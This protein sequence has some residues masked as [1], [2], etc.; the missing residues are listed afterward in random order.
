MSTRRF[1]IELGG[2]PTAGRR[3]LEALDLA[4]G[5][6]AYEHRVTLVLHPAALARLAT[7]RG[8][9]ELA[10]RL[11]RVAAT[12]LEALTGAT[13]APDHVGP[14]TLRSGDVAALRDDADAV[15]VF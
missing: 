2:G 14:L 5:L 3:T 9:P 12:G 15:L 6:A 7:A 11:E 1:C 10:E 13:E 8:D 4:T